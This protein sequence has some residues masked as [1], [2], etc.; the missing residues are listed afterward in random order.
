MM[1]NSQVIEQFLKSLDTGIHNLKPQVERLISKSFEDRCNECSGDDA[2][3]TIRVGNTYAYVIVSLGFAYLK[4]K[5]VDTAS[6]PIMQ[7]LE[8]VKSYMNRE[9]RVKAGADDAQKEGANSGEAV[10]RFIKGVLGSPAISDENF[11]GKHTR[12]EESGEAKEREEIRRKVVEK[13]KTKGKSK[14]VMGKVNK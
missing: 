7:D 13:S 11:K 3:E 4:S 12:F 5:G 9:K 1:E 10:K 14:K 8:R 2:L 6:H